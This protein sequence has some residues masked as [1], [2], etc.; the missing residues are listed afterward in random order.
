MTNVFL[1][2]A[3]ELPFKST[4]FEFIQ[5]TNLTF[6]L[7]AHLSSIDKYGILLYLTNKKF[8]LYHWDEKINKKKKLTSLRSR[9][10]QVRWKKNESVYEHSLIS[11]L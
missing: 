2:S 7:E 3:W 1:R 8:D 11:S 6:I 4:Y 5:F 9:M 10:E